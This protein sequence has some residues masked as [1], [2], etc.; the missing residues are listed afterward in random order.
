MY[1]KTIFENTRKIKDISAVNN[2]KGE[3]YGFVTKYI[4]KNVL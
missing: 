4:I 2:I 1:I 3:I